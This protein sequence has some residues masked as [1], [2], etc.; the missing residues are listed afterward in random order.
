MHKNFQKK[1][2]KFYVKKCDKLLQNVLECGTIYVATALM[3]L[4]GIY[5]IA[6]KPEVARYMYAVSSAEYV[7]FENG[8]EK[9]FGIVEFQA[10]ILLKCPKIVG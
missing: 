9:N 2:K 6:L 3:V 10:G 8:R 5:G 1:A 4:C 7:R